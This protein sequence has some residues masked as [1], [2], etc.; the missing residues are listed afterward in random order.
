MFDSQFKATLEP[1]GVDTHIDTDT[2]TSS[3]QEPKKSTSKSTAAKKKKS[4]DEPAKKKKSSDEPAKK[5]KKDSDGPAKK[6]KKSSDE[7]SKKK[8]DSDEP[9][10]K[11]AKKKKD[12]QSAKD[13]T[14]SHPKDSLHNIL[15]DK[16]AKSKKDTADVQS[17]V[18]EEPDPVL[19]SLFVEHP[20]PL[21]DHVLKVDMP[22]FKN[23]LRQ[24]KSSQSAIWKIANPRL[25]RDFNLYEGMPTQPQGLTGDPVQYQFR[26]DDAVSSIILLS[27]F[28]MA[29][30]IAESWKFVRSQ[31]RNFFITRE[32]PN[33]FAERD[34]NELSGR[35]FLVVQTCFLL[36]LLFFTSTKEL[37]PDVFRQVS[38]RLILVAGTAVS[39]LYYGLKI[40]IY[41]IVNHTFFT[42]AK[43][44]MWSNI[45]F[46]S[47]LL[48]GFSLMPITLL[49]VFCDVPFADV[50]LPCVLLLS[51][52]KILLLYKC[53]RIFFSSLLG[54][55]HL[56]LYFCALEIIPMGLFA[57]SLYGLGN[58]LLTL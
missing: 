10:K 4:S 7:P 51:V 48:T 49:V 36:S 41:N 39:L 23:L 55:V 37:L 42:P 50:T 26:N 18:F 52:I 27:F 21:A 40:T 31:L 3:A 57:A 43:C 17:F 5:K 54:C 13:A 53:F 1:E 32:R 47:I 22:E 46:V 28:L 12:G 11:K 19:G 30:V 33:L 20:A 38:P 29:W 34:D 58:F 56:I 44:I 14:G 35:L 2:E 8:K 16:H 24:D 45:H 9:A 25:V 6:K 15:K